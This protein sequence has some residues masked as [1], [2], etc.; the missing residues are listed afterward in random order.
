MR[1]DWVDYGEAYEGGTDRVTGTVKVLRAVACEEL[2]DDRDILL[3]LPPSYETANRTYP[4]LYMQDGQNLFDETTSFAGEWRV[5]ETL[6]ELAT[7]GIEAIVVGIP[8][9]GEKRLDEYSPFED[10]RFGGGMAPAYVR[11]VADVVKPLVDASFRT[12]TRSQETAVVGS[13]M[14][15]LVSLYAFFER[16]D[17]FGLVGAVSPSVG[18][19]RGALIR[20]LQR[21]PFSPGRIYI[22]VGTHEGSPR[23]RDHLQLR[24]EPGAYVTMVRH[25]RDILVEKGYREGRDLLYVEDEGALHN[26]EAWARRFPRAVRFLID[27]KAG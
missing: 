25:A 6:E 4:T 16:P 12:T 7:D 11:F 22:D 23:H 10:V 18:F 20:Y 24:R 3:Y 27:G 5:D 21:A 9:A 13:S 26:E 19:A 1:T 14:G 17:T 2:G 8:N 15:A